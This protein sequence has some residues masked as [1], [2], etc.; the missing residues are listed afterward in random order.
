MLQCLQFDLQEFIAA[1]SL[2]GKSSD[3]EPTLRMTINM[4]MMMIIM[5]IMR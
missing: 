4:M 5:K 3:V 2:M 1:R